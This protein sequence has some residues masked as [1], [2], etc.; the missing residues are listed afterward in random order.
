MVA[1]GGESRTPFEIAYSFIWEAKG[2]FCWSKR[3]AGEGF[4]IMIDLGGGML[5][6]V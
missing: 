6:S 2:R 4:V 1:F 5:D 3:V